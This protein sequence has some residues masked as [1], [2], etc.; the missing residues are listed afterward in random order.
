MTWLTRARQALCVA[1]LA[2]GAFAV[3][4]FAQV[5]GTPVEV[6]AGAGMFNFDNRAHAKNGPA[7]GGTAG[8]RPITW[9]TLEGYALFGPSKADTA[10]EQ[11]HNFST[12]G[13]DL[14]FNLRSPQS[15][16]IPFITTGMGYGSSHTAG[17][18]PDKLERGTGSLGMGALF[19]MFHPRMH[20][21]LQARDVLFKERNSFE[22]SNHIAVTAG[23]QWTFFGQYMDQDRDKVRDWID[24]CPNTPIGCIV[25]AQGCPSDAD[26]D[27]VCDGLDK[28][29]NTVAG[30]TADANG[31]TTDADGDGVVDGIDQCA[32]TPKGATVDAKGCPHDA[33]A[34]SV[35]DGLDKCPD[36]P[37]GC[38]VD[39]TG[40]TI[41]TDGDGVC[42]ALDRCA[43]TPAGESVG[44]S[45]CPT[46][47]GTF[48]RALLD[49]GRVI[50]TG[51]RFR[52][53]EKP[54]IDSTS[55]AVLNDLGRVLVQY[56]DLKFEVG[57]P[58]DVKGK[59]AE[60]ERLSLDQDKAIL[61]YLKN[62]FLS[63]DIGKYTMRGY[64]VIPGMTLPPPPLGKKGWRAELRVVNPDQLPKE[65]EK[66][67]R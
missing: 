53:G 54:T 38:T 17:T 33:D 63:I 40:C 49:S 44:P 67:S 23:V 10:P 50:V 42:D 30:A 1:V 37:K 51:I 35:Y 36:T 16:V 47:I 22:F 13:V 4:A 65:R 59:Q 20:L 28:C 52:G 32:D 27:G 34:D 6:S 19:N 62:K 58:T 3:P 25:S 12:F 8:W 7:F 64:A 57:G 21:R 11:D 29:P 61:D 24:T 56:P 18:P 9:L 48:E 60:K 39:A 2:A 31:C 45:G 43:N 14:R 55:T 66:R 26:S 46:T 5:G 15:R 41:D